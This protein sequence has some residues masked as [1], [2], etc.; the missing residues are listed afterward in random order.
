MIISEIH[1]SGNT[2]SSKLFNNVTLYNFLVSK[3]PTLTKIDFDI[4]LKYWM[5]GSDGKKCTVREIDGMKF[6]KFGDK[7]V[8]MIT[9]DDIGII[10]IQSSI[11]NL[12]NRNVEFQ[13]K[14]N[15]IDTKSVL[16]L[17]KS[18]QKEA[19]KKLLTRK[20]LL[21]KSYNHSSKLYDELSTILMKINDSNL[22]HEIYNQLVTSSKIL[23]NM[24]SKVS[25]EDI[26]NVRLDIDEQIAKESEISEAL[27]STEEQHDDEELEDELKQLYAEVNKDKTA[28]TKEKTEDSELLDKLN[29]LTVTD[30]SPTDETLTKQ[31]AEP[32]A[33]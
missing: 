1:K 12:E 26:D 28:Q 8:E 7:Q 22:N 20:K 25:L 13:A 4:F 11:T 14:I 16:V 17:P 2:Y 24:N 15:Q 5:K 31:S 33:N 19:L 6:I 29:K 23:Q 9:D 21:I 3:I 27:V 10:N 18:E 30:R 32:I